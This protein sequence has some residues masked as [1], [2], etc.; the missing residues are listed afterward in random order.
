MPMGERIVASDIALPRH[1]GIKNF[2]VHR[3]IAG[4]PVEESIILLP[5]VDRQGI[6]IEVDLLEPIGW[7]CT[8]DEALDILVGGD[9][10]VYCRHANLV[11]VWRQEIPLVSPQDSVSLLFDYLRD[12]IVGEQMEIDRCELFVKYWLLDC[13][14]IREM[15]KDVFNRK[16]IEALIEG[17]ADPFI[18]TEGLDAMCNLLWSDEEQ[19]FRIHTMWIGEEMDRL[20]L[21]VDGDLSDASSSE[22]SPDDTEDSIDDTETQRSESP[23]LGTDGDDSDDNDDDGGT[24]PIV[25]GEA[26][27]TVSYSAVF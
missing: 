9:E 23:P 26:N 19:H 8:A 24:V 7:Y 21:L 6:R 15:V 27:P 12:L 4:R 1:N 13:I 10:L 20:G 18:E 17:T 5:R 3:T 25:S 22:L 2:M 16:Y 14:K 11:S